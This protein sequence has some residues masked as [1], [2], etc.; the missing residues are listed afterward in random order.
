MGSLVRLHGIVCRIF[1]WLNYYAL[2]PNE[3]N[4][5]VSRTV[6]KCKIYLVGMCVWKYLSS[7][8]SNPTRYW[9]YSI[10]LGDLNKE[11]RPAR[12]DCAVSESLRRREWCRKLRKLRDSSVPGSG[13]PYFHFCNISILYWSF[14]TRN[15][16]AF[17]FTSNKRLL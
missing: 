2:L 9:S 5:E 10:P 1:Y 4:E 3:T 16:R 11:F 8:R 12:V 6:E 17:C 7:T 15:L 14:G 13:P